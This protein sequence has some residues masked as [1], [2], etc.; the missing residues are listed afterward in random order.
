MRAELDKIG[1][2]TLLFLTD[3]FDYTLHDNDAAGAQF[4]G[5]ACGLCTRP[6]WTVRTRNL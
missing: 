4:A 2:P 6:A 3:W 5:A 1:V